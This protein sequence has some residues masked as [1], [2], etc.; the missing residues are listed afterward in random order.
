M[1]GAMTAAI[2]VYYNPRCSKCR[3]A[4]DLLDERGADYELIE[5]L[6][7][8]PT[9]AELEDLLVKLGSDDP[10]TLIRTKEAAYA[11]LGL[12]DAD[13]DRLLEALVAHPQLLER[14]IVVSGARA[15]VARPPEELLGLL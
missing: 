14:P 1:L 6:D 12:A 4:R 10:R 13:R 8:P 7:R 2:R 3:R 9:R 5:Y 15:V 11:T